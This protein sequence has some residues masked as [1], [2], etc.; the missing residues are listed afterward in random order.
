MAFFAYGQQ[1]CLAKDTGRGPILISLHTTPCMIT[2]VKVDLLMCKDPGSHY[3]SQKNT[4]FSTE[5][6]QNKVCLAS[7]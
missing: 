5:K 1:S 7:K 6:A 3:L 4:V 2:D